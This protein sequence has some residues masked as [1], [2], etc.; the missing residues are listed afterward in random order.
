M[1]DY[2]YDQPGAYFITVCVKDHKC[3]LGRVVGVDDHIDPRVV[4]SRIGIIVEK[5]TRLIP[6]VDHYVVMPN[7]VHMILRISS[8]VPGDGPMWS[9]APTDAKV[10][11]LIRTWKT[12]IS[13]ELGES[14]FQRSYYDHVIRNEQDY[15][16]I[17][18]YILGNP[19]KWYE[20][21]YYSEI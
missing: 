15:T 16:N 12:L 13:K 6:G 19:G 2:S 7:H 11:T 5:Y 9:S 14:I 18:Q 21:R 20:D 3:L 10:P 8:D 4:L 17:A 1:P